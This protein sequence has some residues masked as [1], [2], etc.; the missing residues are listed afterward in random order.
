MSLRENLTRLLSGYIAAG[1]PV[2]DDVVAL[3]A[4]AQTSVM[5]PLTDAM[6]AVIRNET[7]VYDSEDSLYAALCT[8]ASQSALATNQNSTEHVVM[9]GKEFLCLHCSKSYEPNLPC[10]IPMLTGMIK[11]FS[12]EHQDCLGPAQVF[13]SR[14]MAK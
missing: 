13:H 3:I 12:D 2:I 7:D 4:N 9:R 8:A 1:S 6:R 5:P 11:T 10:S 14:E